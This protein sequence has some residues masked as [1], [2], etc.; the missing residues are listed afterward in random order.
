MNMSDHF[1]RTRYR[2]QKQNQKGIRVLGILLGNQIGSILD[3]SNSIEVKTNGVEPD[4]SYARDRF[5][6]YK[7]IPLF[8]DLEILGWYRVDDSRSD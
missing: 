6:E 8:K 1:T 2:S 5:A 4:L 7:K 3:I